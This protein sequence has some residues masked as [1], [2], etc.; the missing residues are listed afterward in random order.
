VFEAIGPENPLAATTFSFL[1]AATNVPV[2]CVTLLDGQAYGRAGIRGTLFADAAIG[3]V[4]CTLAAWML[5]RFY[6]KTRS[7]AEQPTSVMEAMVDET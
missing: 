5:A 1:T 3:I 6:A 7:D 2:T 4:T